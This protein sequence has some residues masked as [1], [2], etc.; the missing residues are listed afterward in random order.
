MSTPEGR[1]QKKFMEKMYEH[2]P[3]CWGMVYSPGK[4][5]VRGIPDCIFCIHGK[6]HA[7][8]LKVNAETTALQLHNIKMIRAAGGKAMV[9][10]KGGEMPWDSMK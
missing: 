10:T 7:Y 8:E 5:G 4:Y 6:L 1:F 2:F 3:G 9:V